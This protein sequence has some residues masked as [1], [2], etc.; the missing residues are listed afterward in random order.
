MARVSPWIFV[1]MA[2]T[3]LRRHPIRSS[4]ALLGIV[5][6]IAA[7]IAT[8]A[9]GKGAD[10]E[11]QK[12]ILAMGKNTI[13]IFSG[14]FLNQVQKASIKEQPLTDRDYQALRF[15]LD[16][17]E[18]GT[19]L[20]F[21]KKLVRYKGK[22][23]LADIQGVNEE[24]IKLSTRQIH[25]GNFF[26]S[27]HVHNATKVAILGSD[28]AKELFGKVNP[29]GET[30]MIQKFPFK[31]LG[32]WEEIQS[33]QNVFQNPNLEIIVPLSAVWQKLIFTQRNVVHSLVLSPKN[34]EHSTQL[35]VSIKRILRFLH[36]LKDEPDDFTILDQ[37]AILKAAKKSSK[38]LNQ[39]ILVAAA[40]SLLVG[41]IGIMNI[42]LVSMVERKKEIGLK[43]AI[44]ATPTH[45]LFQFLIESLLLCFIGGL[46][47]IGAGIGVT[48][49]LGYIGE[50][51]WLLERE[52]IYI[53]LLTTCCVGIF[54]G[55][56]PAYQASRLHPIDA[57]HST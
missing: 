6:G 36:Q 52:P 1:Q 26:S 41:G 56:Y 37:Q 57:L 46:L 54:F 4:L 53:A 16:Q 25:F 30:I 22:Q 21:D 17:I 9:I 50:F 23:I 10:L 7:L 18:A 32:V 19:P 5:I 45:I 12:D 48:Y 24:F 29:I 42:M 43:M 34:K 28:I 14:N 51:P 44:G 47:G 55:F 49:L 33:D 11:I 39:F 13:T 31:V 2:F 38:R 20:I 8:M 3:S 40:T 27:F 35:V 15:Q